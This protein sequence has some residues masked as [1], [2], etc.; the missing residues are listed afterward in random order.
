MHDDE[1]TGR[2]VRV[3]ADE[4][5]RILVPRLR[6][7]QLLE[8]TPRPE[9]RDRRALTVAPGGRSRPAAGDRPRR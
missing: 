9:L 7:D 6:P 8:L 4:T 1:I 3:D 2:A 5:I